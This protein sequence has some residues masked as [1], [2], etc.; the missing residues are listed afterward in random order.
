MIACACIA[1]RAEQATWQGQTGWW[2]LV[3]SVMPWQVAPVNQRADNTKHGRLQVAAAWYGRRGSQQRQMATNAT[4]LLDRRSMRLAGVDGT[5]ECTRR[6]RDR[7]EKTPEETPC[8]RWTRV[9]RSNIAE[10][11]RAYSKQRARLV[12]RPV[13]QYAQQGDLRRLHLQLRRVAEGKEGQAAESKERQAVY[14]TIVLIIEDMRQLGMRVGATEIA[15]QVQVLG[16]LGEYQRAVEAWQ[17]GVAWTQGTRHLFRQTHQHALVAAVALKDASIVRDV[18]DASMRVMTMSREQTGQEKQQRPERGFF[19]ALFPGRAHAMRNSSEGSWTDS[20]DRT[21][22]PARLRAAF[23]AQLLRDVRT[24]A[25]DD[26]RL[27]QRTA[28]YLMRALFDEGRRD[29]ALRVYAEAGAATREMVCE[30]VHGLSRHGQLDAAYSVLVGVTREQRSTFAWNAYLN[31]LLGS[32]RWGSCAAHWPEAV[33][34]RLARVMTQMAAD[35]ALADTA[36]H[37]IWLRACFRSGHWLLAVRYFARHGAETGGSTACWDVL[38]RGLLATDS[39]GAQRAGW[40]LIG[41]LERR[42]ALPKDQRLA[43]TVLQHVLRLVTTHGE[44][45]FRPDWALVD[46]A[47]AWASA[48][49]PRMRKNTCAVV[50]GALVRGGRLHG[51]LDVHAAMRARALWPS[52]AVNCMLV[53]ALADAELQQPHGSLSCAVA[54]ASAFA[55]KELPWQ[56]RGAAYA[57]L[58]RLAMQHRAF[59]VAWHIIDRHY[60]ALGGADVLPRPFP[61]ARMYSMALNSALLLGAHDQHRLLLARIQHHLPLVEPYAPLAARRMV[62]IYYYFAG[63][64]RT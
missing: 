49:L 32:M 20:D 63:Q 6:R 57:G 34:D 22:E 54:R 26:R 7:L 29:D 2:Q 21:W 55:E 30:A 50:I 36:T 13:Q 53:R 25:V 24:W 14:E 46:R 62:Q 19:W 3:E 27:Q 59:D 43:D 5:E 28:Q 42:S 41:S 33:L 58:M 44:P 48:G 12:D 51:A 64:H 4:A 52:L 9:D 18:Y 38:L 15:V 23:L 61:D 47:F 16:R 8:W 39:A 37:S 60:P 17:A 11:V 45:V 1:R 35:G 10:T 56:H 31:G 40:R